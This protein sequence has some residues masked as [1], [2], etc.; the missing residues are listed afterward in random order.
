MTWSNFKSR[1]HERYTTRAFPYQVA[2]NPTGLGMIELMDN[3]CSAR[4]LAYRK[5]HDM[6][7]QLRYCFANSVDADQFSETFGG[8][9]VDIATREAPDARIWRT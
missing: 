2:C 3:Y 9:R 6:R 8:W 4:F 7:G 1:S 5:R